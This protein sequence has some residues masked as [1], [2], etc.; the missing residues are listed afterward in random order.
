MTIT[1]ENFGSLQM[2]GV[3]AV[4]VPVDVDAAATRLSKAITF[5]TISNQDRAD[6]DEK[7][8]DGLHRY[9]ESAFPLVH[10]KLKRETLGE[11]RRFSLLYTWEGKD[12]SLPAIVLMGHQDV[13]PVVP[14]TE[15]I[16]E[17]PPF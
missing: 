16:W 15:K 1:H 4:P 2:K 10:K 11:P 13:V 12:P 5:P 14:G 17:H 9:L 7:A 3:A 8:F 6:F